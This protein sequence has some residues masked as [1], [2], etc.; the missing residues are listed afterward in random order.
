MSPLAEVRAQ[1]RDRHDELVAAGI[2]LAEHLGAPDVAAAL[3][4]I[5]A[6]ASGRLRIGLVGE[7]AVKARLINAFLAR[8]VLDPLRGQGRVRRIV[9]G[10]ADRVTL[11]TSPPLALDSS[12]ATWARVDALP[13]EVSL[14]VEVKSDAL[15]GAD[16][17]VVDA[18][19]SRA[20]YAEAGWRALQ[21]CHVAVLVVSASSMVTRAETDLLRNLRE[22]VGPPLVAAWVTG[23]A[24]VAEVERGEVVLEIRRAVRRHAPGAAVCVVAA[25]DSGGELVA[26]QL[27]A[28][29][30]IHRADEGRAWQLQA[31]LR[32]AV[33]D[34][35]L[36]AQEL[37]RLA[38]AAQDDGAAARQ[39]L[40]RHLAHE[41]E[42]LQRLRLQRWERAA[43]RIAVIAEDVATA[44][45]D[46]IRTLHHSLDRAPSAAAWW[47]DAAPAEIDRFLAV[48]SA[49][50]DG[51]LGVLVAEELAWVRE[52][53]RK[54]GI[55]I[56]VTIDVP[57]P[58]LAEAPMAV[59]PEDAGARLRFL[60]G[61]SAKVL[62]VL[63]PALSSYVPVKGLD[64]LAEHA[65][66]PAIAQA[67]VT[68]KRRAR[69]WAASEVRHAIDRL[70]ADAEQRVYGFDADLFTLVADEMERR[71]T[72]ARVQLDSGGDRV[73]EL[74]SAITELHSLGEATSQH[75]GKR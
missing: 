28:L 36:R 1:P 62:G 50:V 72:A 23:M 21:L 6:D 27:A 29:V 53:L 4:G 5:T 9:P 8:D 22:R 44:Q 16:V 57:D 46:E 25:G 54:A 32:T 59:L 75:G 64:K 3:R 45:A 15:Q 40:E 41:L 38:R 51:R 70:S 2:R 7:Q 61:L 58:P 68:D 24:G 55:E 13:P 18:P 56:S 20:L 74:Q 39:E 52:E 26:E 43:P 17:T 60:S 49:R 71:H 30:A 11:G 73:A 66:A 34:L 12:G 47:Q 63:E 69:A 67:E 65:F 14:E 48:L 35:M 19:M 31:R 42:A 37:L 33:G 10:P